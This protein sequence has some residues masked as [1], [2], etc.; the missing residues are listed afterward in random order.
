HAGLFDHAGEE[1]R[2][3]LLDAPAFRRADEVDVRTKKRLVM[4]VHVP[5]D[6][7]AQ[8]ARAQRGEAGQRV[9]MEVAV[10]EREDGFALDLPAL[11]S[12]RFADERLADVEPDHA[13]R[14][15]A[16]VSRSASEVTL[17]RRG[18]PSTTLTRPPTAST[19]PAQS[20]ASPASVWARRSMS[21]TKAC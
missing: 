21:A 9:G 17:S 12:G 18:S 14:H 1:A 20:V 2:V 19:R 15:P 3:R 10:C 8:A 4:G 7:E 11:V 13:Q 5:R 16:T 6:A